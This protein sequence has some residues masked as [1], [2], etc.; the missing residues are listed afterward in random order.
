MKQWG[1]KLAQV[2][3]ASVSVC[4][5]T[6]FIVLFNFK[7]KILDHYTVLESFTA[8]VQVQYCTIIKKGNNK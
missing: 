5:T 4:A 6:P 3:N 2:G 1:R 7:F 8:P